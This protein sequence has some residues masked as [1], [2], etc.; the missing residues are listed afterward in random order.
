MANFKNYANSSNLP[1]VGIKLSLGGTT[2]STKYGGILFRATSTYSN[3]QQ[4]EFWVGATKCMYL[5]KSSLVALGNISAEGEVTAGSDIRFKQVLQDLPALSP[6]VISRA[7]LFRFRWTDRSDSSVHIGSSAQ[8]WQGVLP[9]LVT[10]SEFLT[11]N[12][13]VLATAIG[14]LNSR[15]IDSM[16]ERI[17]R[18]EAE[19]TALKHELETLKQNRL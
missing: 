6:E 18:L 17:A 2:E 13:P 14:I 19:N 5:N 12:Y 16:E 15:R 10:G 11:L 9:E 1:S 3:N 8:Y 7:P 4:L